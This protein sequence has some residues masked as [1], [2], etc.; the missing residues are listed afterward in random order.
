MN[1]AEDGQCTDEETAGEF[2]ERIEINLLLEGIFR[3]YGFDFRNYVFSSIKRRIW[4]RIRAERL[5]SV[6]SLSG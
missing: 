1:S 2:L 5:N 4:Y 3:Y 6:S